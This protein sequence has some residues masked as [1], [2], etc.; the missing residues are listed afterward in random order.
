MDVI[1]GDKPFKS[2]H[3]LVVAGVARDLCLVVPDQPDLGHLSAYQGFDT[4]NGFF[5]NIL[6]RIYK[7]RLELD[8]GPTRT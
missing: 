6:D 7:V 5:P 4:N 2:I 8:G 1:E 3:D